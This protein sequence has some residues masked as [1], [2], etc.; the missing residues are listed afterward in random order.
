MT[1]ER[2]INAERINIVDREG[3]V[4]LALFNPDRMPDWQ[5]GGVTYPGRQKSLPIAGLMFYDGDG[6]EC[7]GLIYT[8]GAEGGRHTQFLSLTFDAHQQDQTV[9]LISTDEDGRRRYGLQFFD[10]PER[11]FAEDLVGVNAVRGMPEGPEKDAAWARVLEGHVARA[12]FGRQQDGTAEMVLHDA[13]GHPRLRMAVGLEGEP[14]VEFLEA[15]GRV[16]YRLPPDS[17]DPG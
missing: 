3:R 6:N 13:S 2:E 8:S 16:T 14:V 11:S 10:R 12:F 7:G 1:D 5:V 9:Q 4:R 17:T 15:G